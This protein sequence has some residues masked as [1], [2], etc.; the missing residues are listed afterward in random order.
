MTGLITQPQVISTAAAD[1]AKINSVIGAAKS[2][3]A[4]PTTGVI[5]AAEDEVSAAAAK[6]FGSFGQEYQALLG[7]ASAFHEEFVAALGSAAST[8]SLTEAANASPLGG[9]ISEVEYLLGLD[10]S[11]IPK[12]FVPGTPV[13]QPPQTP[14]TLG[15]IIGG[16]GLP[17]PPPS[18]VT[19]VLPY[20][21]QMVTP[22]S[23]TA[24]F[25]P[26]GLYPL[27]GIKSLPFDTS[28]AQ[29]LQILDTSIKNALAPGSGINSVTV[30]GYSQSA[31]IASLE[32]RN[33]A[34]LPPGM[35]P[36][37]HQLSFTFLGDQMAPNGGIFARFPGLPAGTDLRLPS[38]GITFLGA[39]PSNT[40]YPTNI[41][42]LEYDG[43]ADFPQ[44]PLNFVSDLNAFAGIAFVHGT[45]PT[46][47]PSAL[48]PGYAIQSLPTS[49]GYSGV[50]NYYMITTPNGL[51][52]LEPIRSIPLLGNPIADLLQPDLT[53]IVNL[54]Y[55][56]PA[57]G[58]SQ[59]PADQ[60]TY[61][62]LFPHVSQALIA[63]DLITGAQQG[64]AAFVHD[65]QAEASSVSLASIT[66]P[67]SGTS[68]AGLSLP[69]LTS[70]VASLSP[71]S[72]ING[73]QT[74]STNIANTIASTA[75]NAYSVLLPTADIA[76]ALITA[77]PSYDL[78]LVLSGVQQ[79]LGG[80][81]LGG[82]Q[83]ALVA[84]FA[85]DTALLTMAGGFELLVLLD[86]AGLSL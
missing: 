75:S 52:L 47:N 27:T 56:N 55:G 7:Q 51:P 68:G 64:G 17:V 29:G 26:E 73:I 38:L 83:Y 67:L 30:L 61:F 81:V 54:G 74:A 21:E 85:A 76:N 24:L 2:A 40:I 5:A 77:L 1:V 59:G 71:D 49:P 44:Y 66:S 53:T 8:Y 22:T 36:T 50:T 3:A 10:P 78:N 23:L 69:S 18:Y 84:P 48:P 65:I 79:A 19:A 45:Y 13:G 80:D 39:T 16:S 70:A 42:T 62:G 35:A 31:D 28:V 33:L 43:Y 60:Q 63:Q 37:A 57:Y 32:M 14:P 9:L 25:T 41:F 20:V 4:G 82:L 6:L 12:P 86:A 46:L 34:A 15:L 11:A 72:I 58:W